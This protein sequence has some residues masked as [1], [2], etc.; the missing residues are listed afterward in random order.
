MHRDM[1]SSVYWFLDRNAVEEVH[2][3]KRLEQRTEPLARWNW[4]E[5]YRTVEQ[6]KADYVNDWYTV[7]LNLRSLY[8]F[9]SVALET[10]TELIMHLCF[11]LFVITL[12]A[13]FLQPDDL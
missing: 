7:G 9:V 10:I 13:V 11:S 1:V 8:L 2:Q 6:V 5:K 4:G 3:Y 12:A